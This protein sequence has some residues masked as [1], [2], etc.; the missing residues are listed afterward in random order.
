MGRPR[1]TLDI[2][3]LVKGGRNFSRAVKALSELYPDLEVRQ[4]T[5]LTGFFVP[6]EKH[7][8]IDVSYPNRADNAETLANAIWTEDQEIGVR[9]RIPTLEEA[10]ANKY[11]AMLALTRSLPKRMLDAVDFAWMV[12]HST[13][14]GRAAID[15]PRLEVLGELVWPRGGRKE[16]LSLV[17]L[18]KAGRAINIESL[19]PL[20]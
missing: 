15:L 1:N 13:D 14:E 20:A 8:V 11:G 5:K 4:L 12:L 19:H 7:S 3:I 6:G 2:D 16:I 10:L 9:Y 18:V 17:E